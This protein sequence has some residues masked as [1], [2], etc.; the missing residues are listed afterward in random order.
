MLD[1]L[2]RL[3]PTPLVA[4]PSTVPITPVAA[5]LAGA[6]VPVFWVLLL[7]VLMRTFWRS[8]G[9]DITPDDQSVARGILVEH[10]SGSLSYQTMWSGQ[11]Y[12]F[13]DD[14]STYVAYRVVAGVA[15]TTAG[16]VG[17]AH[18]MP[19][20]LA[21]FAAYC[22]RRAWIPC[23]YGV[24]D[25]LARQCAWL[26]WRRLHVGDEAV[27]DLRALA[28]RGRRWQDIRTARS[29]AA[30]ANVR[31]LWCSLRHVAP[32][33]LDQVREMSEEW[34]ATKGLPEMG[35]TLGGL[36]EALD[37]EVRCLLAVDEDN[38]VHAMT[39]WLPIHRA[40]RPVGWT[41]DLMRRRRESL[42]GVMEFLIATAA[43]QFRT[44]GI[45]ELSLS[46]TPFTVATDAQ[47]RAATRLMV[48]AARILEPV[49]GF[50]SLLT[51]KD[52]FQPAYRPLFLTYPD[53]TALPAI[54]NAVGRA[55]LPA[56]TLRQTA[57][58]LAGALR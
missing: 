54:G 4:R 46:G 34:L 55:Y 5:A 38:H 52:K 6:T 41:L 8:A 50:R 49:Y 33:V 27:L 53:P 47:P 31:P 1:F 12:W 56:L 37:D 35:F 19:A 48:G 24:T 26:G 15:L 30:R 18:A 11:R 44:E 17:P 14:G 43:E 21:G 39:S 10:G 42:P 20:A 23:L 9:A 36:D 51:F 29:K 28:F 7:G 2:A 45:A 32:E 16:P 13:T 40:G 22:D 57:R 58:M 25:D 3:A